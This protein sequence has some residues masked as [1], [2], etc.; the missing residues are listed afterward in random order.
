[1]S[2]RIF[3]TAAIAIDR[4]RSAPRPP[5][6]R[7]PTCRRPWPRPLPRP[8]RSRTHGRS[9]PGS[10]CT[11][12][13]PPPPSRTRLTPTVTR[14]APAGPPT[15]PTDPEPISSARAGNASHDASG[16]DYDNGLGIVGSLLV[17][18]AIAGIASRTRR[19]GRARIAA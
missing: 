9:T 16:V 4:R 7:P 14:R 11:R 13:A 19:A 15:W 6:R 1:M 12:P 17:L 10:G 2:R 18:G 5:S 3:R 8:S